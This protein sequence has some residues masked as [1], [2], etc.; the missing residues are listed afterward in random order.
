[1][2]FSEI[3]VRIETEKESHRIWTWFA[4]SIFKVDI[5]RHRHS[6]RKNSLLV[7]TKTEVN[8]EFNTITPPSFPFVEARLKLM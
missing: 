1:M 7:F 5:W 8:N 3:L 2:P 4:E 6:S